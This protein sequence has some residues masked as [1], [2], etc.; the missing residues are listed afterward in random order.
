MNYLEIMP[1]GRTIMTASNIAESDMEGRCIEALSFRNV[2]C[3]I[4]LLIVEALERVQATR[5]AH[6]SAMCVH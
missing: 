4:Q 1:S 5:G 3:F 2:N 6:G